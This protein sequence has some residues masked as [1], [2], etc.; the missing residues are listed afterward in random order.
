MAPIFLK[1]LLR[2]L[3]KSCL[4]L[5]KIEP[6][7]DNIALFASFRRFCGGMVDG[8]VPDDVNDVSDDRDDQNERDPT[9]TS[10]G[11]HHVRAKNTKLQ[12]SQPRCGT[13]AR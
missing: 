5:K 11:Q 8:S 2:N 6:E 1:R 3:N 7:A 13:T 10:Y 4:L 9:R 12:P